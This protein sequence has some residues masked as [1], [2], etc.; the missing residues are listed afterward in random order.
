LEKHTNKDKNSDTHRQH[1]IQWTKSAKTLKRK[2][3]KY[4]KVRKK[5]WNEKSHRD[6]IRK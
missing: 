5:E 3:L 6:Q 4:K 1:E 2:T